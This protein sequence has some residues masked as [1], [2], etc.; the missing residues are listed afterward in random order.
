VHQHS[1]LTLREE[2]DSRPAPASTLQRGS[3]VLLCQHFYPEMISTGIH[4]TELARTLARKGWE[5]TVVSAQPRLA[6]GE[7]SVRVEREMVYENVRVLRVPAWGSHASWMPGRLAFA[8]TYLASSCVAL[9]R[10]R[11]RAQGVLVTTNPPFIGLVGW[12]Y[13]RLAGL[14]YVLIVHDVYPD[15][16]V[17]LGVLRPRSLL[18]RVWLRVTR[19]ILD[20]AALN[21]VIGRDMARIIGARVRRGRD[22]RIRL[23]PNWSDASTVSPVAREENRFV[24]EHGLDGRFVVQYSGRM[25]RTHNLEPLL[26]AAELLRGEP[27]VFQLIG[28]GAKRRRLEERCRERGLENMKFLPYQPLERLDE[29]LSA[30]D[31]SIVCLESHFT[32]LSVPSKTYGVMAAGKPILGFL[33][34]KS[35]IGLTLAEHRCGIVLR[36]PSGEEV[37]ACV[38]DLMRD[39]ARREEMGR[40][41]RRAFLEEFTL[42]HAAERYDLCLAEAFNPA[43]VDA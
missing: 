17:R 41:A 2:A 18:A 13:R 9:F 30:S 21:I 11:K 42:D 35:E 29:V 12:I 8:L 33:D 40:N 28:D 10:L 22:A 4:M 5:I 23:I 37:A 26:E 14:P 38:R 16:A 39:P 25:G 32:G 43:T 20:G 19:L 15:V 7:E 31:L 34:P 3:L 6:L 36:D 1:Q 24:R 27:V